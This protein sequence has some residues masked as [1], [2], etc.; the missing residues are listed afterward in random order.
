MVPLN[1]SKEPKVTPTKSDLREEE[2]KKRE[3]YIPIWAIKIG[4][5]ALVCLL[6]LEFFNY[7]LNN[8]KR[9]QYPISRNVTPKEVQTNI[10]LRALKKPLEFPFLKERAYIVDL[11]EKYERQTDVIEKLQEIISEQ[12]K[13]LRNLQ[14]R[15]YYQPDTISVKS[16]RSK[17]KI[18]NENLDL[19]NY[20]L[21]E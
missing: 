20:S 1:G 10:T 9:T 11:K 6:C 16:Y 12:D 4:L 8:T 3:P 2:N 19:D 18:P 7:F 21:E 14:V 13:A 5:V 15:N 17:K